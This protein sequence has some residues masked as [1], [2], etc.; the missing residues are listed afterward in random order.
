MF[1][2]MQ[3]ALPEDHGCLASRNLGEH[4]RAMLEYMTGI[5]SV[6]REVRPDAHCD[7]ILVQGKA[8]DQ[9]DQLQ[10]GW[11]LVWKGNRPGDNRERFSLYSRKPAE[12]GKADNGI[13]RRTE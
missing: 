7:F 4:E 3:R 13:E 11:R 8:R 1:A 12:M 5:I 2:S 6:R 10:G 9:R